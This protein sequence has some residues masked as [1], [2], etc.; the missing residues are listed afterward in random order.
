MFLMWL[1]WLISIM[2]LVLFFEVRGQSMIECVHEDSSLKYWSAFV[3]DS[4]M[5]LYED[6]EVK[7]AVLCEVDGTNMEPRRVMS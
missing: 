6:S 5:K 1:Y 7:N 3:F 4:V 2:E